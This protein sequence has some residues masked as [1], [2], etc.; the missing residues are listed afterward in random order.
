MSLNKI[1]NIYVYIY[2]YIYTLSILYGT[3]SHTAMDAR[4]YTYLVIVQTSSIITTTTITIIIITFSST[5]T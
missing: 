3:L 2:K 4:F 1:N 5:G